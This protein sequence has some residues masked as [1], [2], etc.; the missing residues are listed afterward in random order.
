MRRQRAWSERTGGR[1]TG[2]KDKWNPPLE[3]IIL[4]CKRTT[5]G[6]ILGS[7]WEIIGSKLNPR[8]LNVGLKV[9]VV[10][11]RNFNR[12]SSCQHFAPFRIYQ[13]GPLFRAESQHGF[14]SLQELNVCEKTRVNELC[15]LQIF[16]VPFPIYCTYL[17]FTNNLYRLGILSFSW[18]ISSVDYIS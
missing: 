16:I 18:S 8:T 10:W 3:E 2:G 14:L 1:Q 5:W 6:K 15:L 4:S 11:E 9:G 7:C 12:D 13:E 17:W